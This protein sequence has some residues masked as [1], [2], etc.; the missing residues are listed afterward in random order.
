MS[1][2]AQNQNPNPNALAQRQGGG[3]P[4][5]KPEDEFKIVVAN[6]AKKMLTS[7]M[8]DERGKTAA[9]R[10]AM[11][12]QAAMRAARDPSAIMNCSE[13]SI[14]NCIALC[15]LTDLMPGGAYP[16][17]Y[18]VPQPPH[19]GEQPELQWRINHRG[20]ATL[21]RRD[22]YL[23]L[24]VP[25]ALEDYL[26]LDCGEVVKHVPADATN[27]PY[28]TADDCNLAGVIVVIKQIKNDVS[29]TLFKYWVPFA[30]IRQRRAKSKMRESGPWVDWPIAMAQGAAI[31]E[32]AARAVMPVDSL[33][34]SEALAAED[35]ADAPMVIEASATVTPTRTEAPKQ[36]RKSGN[37]G[38]ARSQE[39]E[40]RQIQERPADLSAEVQEGQRERV[41][42]GQ[43][44]NGDPD[45]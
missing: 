22:G 30:V 23:V 41:P 14:G 13:S 38:P 17:V 20:L 11:A 34:L 1:E 42:A 44:A 43:Q 33:E 24:P 27:T 10:V 5:R 12:M 26:E 6:A 45:M 35:R 40:N 39:P 36:E 8:G 4:A 15:A 18:L 28:W 7:L 32:A 21:A 37:R 9:L 31:R 16:S 29:V 25:V 2:V 3:P 19:K